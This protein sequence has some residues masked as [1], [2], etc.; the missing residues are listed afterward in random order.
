MAP[1]KNATAL[2]K[3]I[4]SHHTSAEDVGRVA[5]AAGAKT[6]GLSH[7]VPAEDASLTDQ[8]WVDAVRTSFTGQIIVGRDL[9]EI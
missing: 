6:L 2:K 4:L 7:L 3:S 5:E 1:L 8:M 9:L